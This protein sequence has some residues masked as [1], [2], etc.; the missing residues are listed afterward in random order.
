MLI[1]EKI[2][3]E[4]IDFYVY[5]FFY[6]KGFNGSGSDFMFYLLIPYL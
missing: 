5:I 6:F 2:N 3:E 4:N 1:L